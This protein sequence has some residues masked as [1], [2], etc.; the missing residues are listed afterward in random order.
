MNL[1]EVLTQAV[2][3]AGPKTQALF[4]DAEQ[5]LQMLEASDSGRASVIRKQLAETISKGQNPSGLIKGLDKVYYSSLARAEKSQT[6]SESRDKEQKSIAPEEA[7]LQIENALNIGDERGIK[8]SDQEI[9]SAAL[10]VSKGNMKGAAKIAGNLVKGIES[11]IKLQ[12]DEDKEV[13][14]TPDGMQFTV[15][16]KTGTI[17]TGG[18]P[19]SRG[20]QNTESFNSFLGKERKED[21]ATVPV[22]GA[23]AQALPEAFTPTPEISQLETI[24]PKP[25]LYAQQT[26]QEGQQ[27][28]PKTTQYIVKAR[29]LY[30][31]GDIQ[32]ALDLLNGTS[33]LSGFPG[34]IQKSDLPDILGVQSPQP[35]Q[36][37]APQSPQPNRTKG[38]TQ[39]QILY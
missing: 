13:R 28:V 2:P 31:Q 8:L 9:K 34:G 26:Q 30:N 19:A 6:T 18:L 20:R 38:G 36:T 3:N 37:T 35:A 21:I 23:I 17:Y 14:T 22:I 27:V 4:N 25:E 10:A 32:G 11:A 24:Q 1:L 12:N 16:K 29:E 7:L 33:L 15:G 39:Y 5:K